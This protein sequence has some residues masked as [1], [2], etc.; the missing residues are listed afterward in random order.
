MS[1]L[2]CLISTL[3]LTALIMHCSEEERDK[4]KPADIW[5]IERDGVPQFINFNYIEL[6]KIGCISKFRSA[7][8]HDYSDAFEHC[9]SM[10]HYFEPRGDVEWTT[11]KIFA[12]VSGT[13][14]RVEPEWAGT[15]VEIESADYPA[16][17]I[18]IFHINLSIQLVVGDKVTAGS[19]LG[20]H[21]SSQTYSDIAVIANDPTHQGRMVS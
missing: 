11:V 1:R 20:T 17:R 19:Q 13:V 21:I 2:A 6:A 3:F 16:F 12:P 7:V 14:T 18:V 8:G 9:R 4:D 5:D 10:K 15:K